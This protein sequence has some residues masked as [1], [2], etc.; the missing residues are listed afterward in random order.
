MAETEP[1]NETQHELD[2]QEPESP[3]PESDQLESIK[4]QRHVLNLMKLIVYALCL[5]MLIHVVV[6][7]IGIEDGKIHLDAGS[8]TMLAP[9]IALFAMLVTGI[10]IFATFQIDQKAMAEA[11]Q[12]AQKAV[13]RAVRSAVETAE[14]EMRSEAREAVSNARE[15]AQ[16]AREL[17]SEANKRNDESKALLE[18]AKGVLQVAMNTGGN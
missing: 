16:D 17:V 14:K 3:K 7:A 6:V 15:I 4:F 5:V 9:T 10:F 2:D 18:N 8:T 12:V 13:D 11:R 1:R